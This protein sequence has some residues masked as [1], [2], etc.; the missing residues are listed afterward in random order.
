[1]AL[2]R[3]KE[4]KQNS[5]IYFWC[6]CIV[7]NKNSK[8]SSLCSSLF[9]LNSLKGTSQLAGYSGKKCFWSTNI[10]KFWENG[11][12]VEL[13]MTLVK[14]PWVE[15]PV[16]KFDNW[17]CVAYFCTRQKWFQVRECW[18]ANMQVPGKLGWL[19]FGSDGRLYLQ[20][21]ETL[22][23]GC[24]PHGIWDLLWRLCHVYPGGRTWW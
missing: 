19:L 18:I 10:M 12:S 21:W 1:M 9:I 17:H 4:E 13:W 5:K 23:Y 14:P 24:S 2:K 11:C 6:S 8:Q 20:N 22:L 16:P 3:K 7:L 15:R